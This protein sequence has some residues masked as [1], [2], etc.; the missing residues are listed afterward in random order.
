MYSSASRPR[1]SA[2]GCRP[3]AAPVTG[4]GA[5]VTFSLAGFEELLTN[6]SLAA[7]AHERHAPASHEPRISLIQDPGQG[8]P[9]CHAAAWGWRMRSRARDYSPRYCESDGP[10]PSKE[11]HTA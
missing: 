6:L 2:S 11:D 3:A 1:S 9:S 4:A 5:L 8:P 10:W 7:R